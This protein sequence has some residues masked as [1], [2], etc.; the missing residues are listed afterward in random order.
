MKRYLIPI[1]TL[2]VFLFLSSCE[3]ENY[4]RG[5]NNGF[6]KGKQEGYN[7]GHSAG[8]AEG[9]TAALAEVLSKSSEGYILFDSVNPNLWKVINWISVITILISLII[10]IGAMIFANVDVDEWR[11]ILA[12]VLVLLLSLLA[13]YLIIPKINLIWFFDPG[14]NALGAFIIYIVTIIVVYFIGK[15]LVDLFYSENVI[16]LEMFIIFVTSFFL[17]FI[18][19]LLLNNRYLFGDKPLFGNNLIICITIGVI[20]FLI[21]SLL[22]PRATKK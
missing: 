8:Y 12:K 10:V 1:L 6:D 18:G 19:Y 21:Y 22:H 3:D 20:G 16:S 17:W 4:N 14:L 2:F 7:Q 11:K 9:H 13:S 5:Y 15:F